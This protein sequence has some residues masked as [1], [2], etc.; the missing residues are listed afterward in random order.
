MRQVSLLSQPPLSAPLAQQVAWL[1]S[2]VQQLALASR[3]EGSRIADPYTITAPGGT[4]GYALAR[5]LNPN[6]ATLAETA[7]VL[8]TLIIDMQRRGMNQKQQ[9]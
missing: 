3:Q 7:A 4:G 2:A 8:G 5:T 6:T 9:P 1:M